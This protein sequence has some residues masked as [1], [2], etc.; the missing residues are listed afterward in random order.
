M[1]ASYDPAMLGSAMAAQTAP[2]SRRSRL[3]RPVVALAAIALIAAGASAVALRKSEELRPKRLVAVEP[4][5]LYRSGQISPR[6]IRGV[7]EDLGI[8]RV[9]WMLHYDEAKPSH[10]AEKAAIEALGIE[11]MHFPLRGDG[12]GKLSRYADAIAAVHEARQA[13]EPVL[14]HCAAGSRRSAAVVAMYELLVEG[15][16]VD[17]AYR[18][19]DRFGARPVAD[20]PLLPYLNENMRELAEELVE[21]GVIERVPDPLPLLRPP[22]PKGVRNRLALAAALRTPGALSTL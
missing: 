22:P 3:R 4:G 11:R 5:G 12:T 13:G 10:R 16:P 6:L 19:L 20:S 9:V 14:V 17:A 2:P 1:R 21:R 15:R 8:R 7:L 18:E